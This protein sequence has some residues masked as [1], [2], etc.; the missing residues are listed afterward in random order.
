MDSIN[1]DFTYY[2]NIITNSELDSSPL[3]DSNTSGF[4]EADYSH[5]IAKDII[6]NITAFCCKND[7]D[8][9]DFLKAA[10]LILFAKYTNNTSTLCAVS[11]DGNP[12]PVFCDIVKTPS[13]LQ[14]ILSLTSQLEESKNHTH[15][16]FAELSSEFEL[17][18]L[19]FITS[20][21]KFYNSFSL[22]DYK[23]IEA[24]I[25]VFFSAD[26]NNFT[27]KVKYNK[28]IYSI[29]TIERFF[30]SYDEVL[31]KISSGVTSIS[32]ISLLSEKLTEELDSFNN[33][34]TPYD[35]T[36]SVVD[37]INAAVN[38]HKDRVAVVYNDKKITYKQFGKITD[39][40]ANY[41]KSLGIGK[42]DIVSIL[43]PRCEYMPIAATGVIKSGAAYQPLDPSYPADR[44]K[45][46][47]EDA[48]AK[49]LISDSALL[50]LV[51]DYN[52]K[53]LTLDE[54][55]NL[56]DCTEK[57]ECP[58]K[59]DLFILL[60]TSGSTGT[61]KGVM[62][63]HKNLVA[64]C[65][66]Y[67]TYYNLNEE[68][69]VA[70]Y[71]S[72][73]FDANMMDTYPALVSGAQIH[74]IDESIRLELL[75]LKDYFEN[76]KITHS[77]ITTQVG[78]Q[79]ADMF[80]DSK[81]PEHLSVG[82]EALVPINPPEYN[83]YNGYGPTECTIF[84]TIFLVDRL[85]KIVPI[86]KPLS[87]IKLYI[88]DK[89]GNRV[90][91]GVPGEL[92]VSGPQVS[93][94]YLNRPEQTE[95][96]FI[97]NNFC[98]NEKYSR[99]YRTGDIVRYLP[100]G[101]VEFIGRRDS[102]VKIRGF[103]IELTEVES[104]IREFDGVRDATVAAFDEPSGGKYIAAYVVSDKEIDINKLNEFI[105]K[106]KP[107]YMVPA[108]TMQIDKIPLNQNQKVN[109]RA[110]PK[111]ERKTDDIIPAQNEIQQ[112]ICDCLAS[113]VGHNEFGI[114]TEFYNT[115]LTSV[116]SIKFIVLLSKELSVTVST[117]NLSEFNTPQKLEEFISNADTGFQTEK[118]DKYPLTQTQMGIYI[119]CMMNPDSVFYNLPG[120]FAFNK[121]I[122]IAKLCDSIKKVLNAHSSVKC[123]IK[124]D[125]D[126][127]IY[128]YPNDE[129]EVNIDI[130]SGSEEE[131]QVFFKNFAKPFD[132]QNGPLFR[133]SVFTTDEHIYLVTDFHHIISDGT[134]IAVFADELNRVMNDEEPI[135]EIFTQFD[136]AISE[137]NA[138]NSDEHEKAKQYY[139]SVFS[140][141]SEC[142]VPDRDTFGETEKC[143]FYKQYNKKLS[144]E[145][146]EN[147]CIKNKITPN[148]FFTSVMGFVLGKYANSD[149]VCFTTIYNGRNDAHTA[150][151]MGMLVKT[152]PVFCALD[153]K[154]AVPTYLSTMQ[155]QLISSMAND[156]YSFA[157]IR[158]T[159]NIKPDIMFVYQGDD[160]VNFE[161][162]GQKTVFEE[163]LSDKAKAAIS[164]NIFLENGVYRYEFE[165]RRDMFTEKFIERMYD[166]ITEAANSFITA[167]NL[168]DINITSAKQAA[169]IESFN[170][171]DYPV[172]L[173][174]VNRLLENMVL[175]NPEMTAVI[176]N[177]KKITYDKL[178]RLANRLAH[179]LI[180]LGVKTNSIIGLVLE[181]DEY[182][183]I[184]RQG[185]I[186]AG[187][188][189]LP[190]VP[191]YPDDRIDF[192]L[193]D[194]ECP[195][196]IT[197]EKIKNKRESLWE[198]KPYKVLTV[199]EL[200]ECE[201]EDNP[202]LDIPVSSLA[203]CLYTSGSTGKPKGVLIEHRN[204]CN[205][206]NSNPINTEIT[207]YTDNGIVS[208]ALAAIT[209]DVSVMEEFIPL[210]NGMTICMANEEEIH[211][212]LALSELLI[213]NKVDIM[214][215]TP[216]YMTN[217]IEVPQMHPALAQ[218]K[219]FDIGAEAFPSTLYGK[220]RKVNKTA[221]IVNSYGP[222]ECTVS[223]TTK[224][225]K[226]G[227]KITIGDPLTNMKLYVV[228]RKNKVLPV[229]ISGEL[230]I[231]G[232]GVGRGY[233]NLPE[234]NKEAFFKYKGLNAY[235]SG[236]LVR[237]TENG[238]IDFLG[239]LDNQVKLRGLRVELD[240][241]ENAINTFDGVKTSKVVV[242][243]NGSEEYLA[244]Y[245][246]AEKEINIEQLTSH[247]KSKLTYYM[248]P[249]ALMQ[250]DKMPLTVNGKIDKKQLPEIGYSSAKREYVAP[251]T[252]LEEELCNKFSE[253]LNI[254]KVGTTD[255]FFE[256]GGTSL[257]ATKIAMY[258]IT[259][260]YPI[261]YKDVFANPTPSQLASFIMNSSENADDKSNIKDYD[262]SAINLLLSKNCIEN[263]EYTQKGELGNILLTGTTGFLGIHVLKEF[264]ISCTGKA[265]CLVRKGRYS[266]CE[267]RLMNMMMYYFD[268]P[269]SDAFENRIVCIDG[270]I[271]DKE[272]M[273]KLASLDCSVVINCAAC[274]K[275]FVNDDTLDKINVEGVK[276][277]IEMCKNSG[278]RL[279]Q[280]STTSVAGEGN[281][282]TVPYTKL[283][284]ENE[285]YFGQIIENDYIRTK[286]LAERSI[287][288]ACAANELD[289]K[290]IRVGNLMS[291]KSDGEFQINF[292][293]NGFMRALNG[294]KTL[295]KFPIS[296]MHSPAEFSPI[297]STAAAV[298]ALASSKNDF[299]VF[300][301]YNSHKIYMSDVIYAMKS[302]GFNIEIVSDKEFD[303]A[304]RSAAKQED[305]SQAVLGL[306]AYATDDENRRYEIMA[307]NRFTSEVLY[308]LDY[309][310]PITDDAYL[311]NAIKALDTLEFFG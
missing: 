211:N 155:E 177:G 213:K 291:R 201:N 267:K 302:Y 277:I 69:R 55:P 271:T 169:L 59:N 150:N 249:G 306:I 178:N 115:G 278:K 266:S 244:G 45:F 294:Y 217:I 220:M 174:S 122:N 303:S 30:I 140:T 63:E 83:F 79:Y 107:P 161:I 251:T 252:P 219:A 73:G 170:N 137:Q 160:F 67:K 89:F 99:I 311:E 129:R 11:V 111:P 36:V 202:E 156:I 28:A 128:M 51:P 194:A 38:Q 19:P 300:H 85:Y 167:K 17:C 272:M 173:V 64:F 80:P 223:C 190:M 26:H 310:W 103:R 34:E 279:V 10:L 114:T 60:Y 245:F 8:I 209:F 233:V 31:T 131:Y 268:R 117:K 224:V 15:I 90:P 136:L 143:G 78:R 235:H 37:M 82:G 238:E 29:D 183:Y 66:W 229:G 3:A 203:Y 222:T 197:T 24:K 309:K 132:L 290:I 258:A 208:L 75:T 162:G 205:F 13:P 273:M 104:I 120:V 264:L 91:V 214:K 159:Y 62:L 248:V 231:C 261:V 257:S 127:N 97:K 165:Y 124:P 215:C 39:K 35:D 126:G 56:P 184:T 102:Q 172:E 116:G 151:M 147:F 176:S 198:G 239:R 270:D 113:V 225:L 44:L 282:L 149:E 70:A 16:S 101:C 281:E 93:R 285:L 157:E 42:E 280:I 265:Y 196:V 228:N 260:G 43:I 68:S 7:I 298:I 221:K 212:P 193:T 138:I 308:R 276:N 218:I 133:I 86:G 5:S 301:A 61:P 275:H 153:D 179:S 123:C 98:N 71:A 119:E 27:A 52:G 289:A 286:F 58:D 33:T 307:D 142:T 250:L 134:S 46:M 296:A 237:W 295:G 288:E 206:V 77:F 48:D 139:D 293:T 108:A 180:N 9:I 253:I 106:N 94:G 234:K 21:E 57:L 195:F 121:T 152:L 304:L 148:V 269:F 76:N 182:V 72:F 23:D 175:K 200:L 227:D 18:S 14:Y 2:R 189:F 125:S 259:K 171:T 154:T 84:T 254:E 256:I 65:N 54:I 204:L 246:T 74:I 88:T 226:D 305:L 287:L 292:V 163:G 145:R 4:E 6:P 192:C 22:S 191:E 25:C 207:N 283:M 185:I 216:S 40:I 262:Y 168:A 12:V 158:R 241:I 299:T 240:E 53:V 181:R 188:A 20:E 146:I 199:Q 1:T 47:M 255:N 41:I 95:K 166:I 109:K 263:I 187:G 284:N 87:N 96:V 105:L 210:C 118:R 232:N 135:G 274:V 230:I 243:N 130:L 144:R 141:V 297:D 110:L 186:K 50:S 92:C 100:D 236:D 81:Y 164:I 49:L 112:K 32:D 247:L 242:K